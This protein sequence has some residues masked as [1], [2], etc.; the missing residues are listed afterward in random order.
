[1]VS[2][3]ADPPLRRSDSRRRRGCADPA[4]G[5]SDLPGKTAVAKPQPSCTSH[6]QSRRNPLPKSNS[7]RG[8]TR[9]VP[10]SPH[11]PVPVSSTNGAV[12][13]NGTLIWEA[14]RD[15]G[16]LD[17]FEKQ[18]LFCVVARQERGVAA[19]TSPLV[20]SSSL[21]SPGQLFRGKACNGW[22]ARGGSH[23]RQQGQE[24]AGQEKLFWLQSHPQR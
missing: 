19:F 20:S 7:S 11:P 12:S 14:F 21:F 1:M 18:V 22:D 24:R 4:C 23:L 8:A 10:G 3:A 6:Y 16:A 15:F 9:R 13:C 17:S 5:R 2:P